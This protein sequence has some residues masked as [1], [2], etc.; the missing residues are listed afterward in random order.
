MTV[1]W[2]PTDSFLPTFSSA[3]GWSQSR[4]YPLANVFPFTEHKDKTSEDG[5][6]ENNERLMNMKKISGHTKHLVQLLQ[7]KEP[8]FNADKT[9]KKTQKW[10]HRWALAIISAGQI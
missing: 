7:G 4:E 2:S 8:D 9:L 6:M 1:V 5:N 3:Y 10:T